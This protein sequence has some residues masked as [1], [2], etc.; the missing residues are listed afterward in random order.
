M[1]TFL[2]QG[3]VWLGGG[4]SGAGFRVAGK[5]GLWADGKGMS[6]C[7]DFLRC[8]YLLSRLGHDLL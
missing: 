4:G 2:V 8:I 3:V 6:L 5:T 1:H 7:A